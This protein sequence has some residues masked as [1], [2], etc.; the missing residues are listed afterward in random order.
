LL[1]EW[2]AVLQYELEL[3]LGQV[4]RSDVVSHGTSPDV[5]EITGVELMGREQG[6]ALVAHVAQNIRP[7][8]QWVHFVDLTA[9]DE[10]VVDGGGSACPL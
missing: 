3:S 2:I 8:G 1:G 6:H 4:K 7:V 10:T 5:R 9:L